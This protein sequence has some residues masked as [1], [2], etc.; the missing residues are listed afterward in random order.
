MLRKILGITPTAKPAGKSTI[1]SRSKAATKRSLIIFI[2]GVLGDSA[3][4]WTSGNGAY[5]PDLI[6]S[7]KA[8][9]GVDALSIGF[10]TNPVHTSSNIEELSIRLGQQLIDEGC[11]DE[12]EAIGLVCHSMGGLIAKRMT[13]YLLEVLKTKANKLRL[14]S[15]F[16]TPTQGSSLA[17]V[18]AWVSGNPQFRDMRPSDVNSLL[19]MI[20]NDWM[21]IMRNRVPGHFNPT[22]VC[23]YETLPMM[24]IHIVPRSKSQHIGD[25]APVAFDLNHADIVKPTSHDDPIYKFL[26]A[27]IKE[28][29]PFNKIQQ[30]SFV[31]RNSTGQS[32]STFKSGESYY[33]TIE[34]E[35]PSWLYLFHSD[36][37]ERVLRYFPSINGGKQTAAS[38]TFRVP[39]DP[40]L[41]IVLDNTVGDEKF[42][43][44]LLEKKD[45]ELG[46]SCEELGSIPDSS[47]DLGQMKKR[48]GLVERNSSSISSPLERYRDQAIQFSFSHE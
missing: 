9:S 6:A 21:S 26:R 22:I 20:D 38:T 11:F 27:R 46:L 25:M 10:T 3:K 44:V 16:A 30:V 31:S 41:A 8:F 28:T 19:Q 1:Y 39:R 45:D 5:W 17:D 15:F 32:C 14:I 23:A 35:K 33:L 43:V 12:Y 47:I 37:K 34:C 42:T 36:S 18:A 7:D 48:G 13:R 2:H 4:T 40:D 24:G 29:L